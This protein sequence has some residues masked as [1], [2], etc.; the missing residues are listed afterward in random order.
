MTA[1]PHTPT[2]VFPDLDGSAGQGPLLL[3]TGGDVLLADITFKS[4]STN[5][6]VLAKLIDAGD[7]LWKKTGANLIGTTVTKT[8]PLHGHQ[9]GTAWT[10]LTI[11]NVPIGWQ[12]I[13]HGGGFD[14]YLPVH[15]LPNGALLTEVGLWWAGGPGHVALPA[16]MP[17]I[18][19]SRMAPESGL[20]TIGVATD[21]SATT[22][23]YQSTHVIALSGLTHTVDTA[24]GFYVLMVSGENGT[25]ALD[26]SALQGAYVKFKPVKAYAF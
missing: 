22:T 14:W 6:G 26:T 25:N 18:R 23:A 4:T 19:V 5:R 7:Y 24:T 21:T 10:L 3:Q 15:D 12:N 17:Q 16:T 20:T 11:G 1:A 9:L 13:T 8:L 2:G